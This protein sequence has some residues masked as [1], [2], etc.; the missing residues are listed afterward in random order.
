M[1]EFVKYTGEI[2]KVNMKLL[3]GL[4]ALG[5]VLVATGLVLIAMQG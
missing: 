1:A 2:K 4:L 5:V 3:V